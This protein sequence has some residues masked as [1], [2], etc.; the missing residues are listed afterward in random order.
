MQTKIAH[1]QPEP[2]PSGYGEVVAVLARSLDAIAQQYSLPLYDGTDNLD[3]YRAAAVQLASGR[4]LGLLRH[5]GT[6]VSEVEVYADAHDDPEAATQELL[7][8]LD[9]PRSSCIWIREREPV[10]AGNPSPH[11]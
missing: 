3:D 4:R 9:L 2:W 1:V 10:S 5:A 6:P 8:A 7:R 11:R